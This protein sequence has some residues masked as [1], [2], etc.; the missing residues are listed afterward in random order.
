MKKLLTLLFVIVI[1]NSNIN[2]QFFFGPFV[3]F[4]SSGLEGAV[5]ITENA[6][7]Q[8]LNTADAGSTAFT[9]GLIIGYQVIPADVTGGLYKLDIAVEG[10]WSS[11]NFFENAWD[12]LNGSGT[13]SVNGLTGGKTNMFS[14]DLLP[15]HR[16]NFDNFILSPFAGLGFGVNLLL[17]SDITTGPPQF[18]AG[19]LT[20]TSEM[21]MGLL[22]FYGTVFKVSS[23][24]QPY[25]Q[26]RHFIP[27]G[28]ETKLTENWESAQGLGT[29]SL[30]FSI[31]DIPGYFN[32]T[33]GVR[34]SF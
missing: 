5:K 22:V 27:F 9:G 11:F 17:T 28:D 21:K 13:F 3:G 34:F 10:S 6:Q 4:K 8:I 24:I 1:S 12:D 25:I 31:A 16:F 30:T 23:I 14:F 32:M 26:I 33:A 18:N 20:G 2:A 29:E 7:P 19:T 15:I